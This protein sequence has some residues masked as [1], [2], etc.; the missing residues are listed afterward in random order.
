MAPLKATEAHRGE[1]THSA[2]WEGV[3]SGTGTVLA[4]DRGAINLWRRG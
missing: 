1:V 4:H 3:N 2:E